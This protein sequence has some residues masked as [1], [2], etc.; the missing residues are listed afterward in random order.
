MLVCWPAAL[1]AEHGSPYGH[2]LVDM[3][4]EPASLILVETA[5]TRDTLW[6][7]EEGLRSGALALVLGGVEAVGL[8]QSRR[9][10]L[11]AAGRTP[12]LLLTAPGAATTLAVA[13]RMRVARC[14]SG[15]HPLDP[16]A[17]GPARFSLVLERCRDSPVMAEGT[18]LELEW[19]HGTH[20]FRL[21]AGLADGAAR[22]RDTLAAAGARA[23]RAG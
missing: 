8:T 21:A 19:C 11:A 17:P 14:R 9:L 12:A 13:T 16:R 4:H 6:V 10:A 3:G 22:P 7:M 2:G 20:R 23:L 15:P 5:R 18:R 1:A